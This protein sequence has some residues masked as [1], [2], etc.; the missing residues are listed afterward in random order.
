MSDRI[1][2]IIGL[3]LSIGYAW[4]AMNIE[5]SFLSD[6]VG[7]KAFP[8]I[9]AAVLGLASITVILKPD[10]DPHWP[11]PVRLLEIAAAVVILLLY[12]MMLPVVGFVIGTALAGAYLTWRLG[13]K[14][15]GSVITGA[16]TS[17]GI[18][19]IFHLILGLS[20]AKGPL[21]F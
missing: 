5:E 17:V 6:A 20:L 16:T 13:S 11:N 12:S 19:V 15:L 14:P 8:L 4:A 7:P 3:A 2:G 21:G 9:I 18:Y 1:F 10:P